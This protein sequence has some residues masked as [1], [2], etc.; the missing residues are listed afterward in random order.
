MNLIGVLRVSTDG[1]AGKDGEGLERQRASVR[2]IAERHGADLQMIEIIDVSGSDVAD[3]LVWNDQ[4]LPALIRDPDAHV[5]ADALDRLVR[6]DSFDLRVLQRLK[7]LRRRIYLPDQTYDLALPT[8]VMIVTMFAA[9]GGHE[10]ASINRRAN[11]GKEAHR[12]AGRW[13]SGS[14]AVGIAYDKKTS[15][16]GYTEDAALVRDAFRAYVE[17]RATADSLALRLGRSR[18][19]MANILR[20]PLYKGLMVIDEKRGE[21]Y[22]KVRDGKQPHRRHVKRAPDEIISVRVYGGEGQLEQLVPDGMWDAAQARLRAN[23]EGQSRS[24]EVTAPQGYFSGFLRPAAAPDVTVDAGQGF[25]RYSLRETRH[26]VYAHTTGA[27]HNNIVRYTCCCKMPRFV[28]SGIGRCDV[29]D[30]PAMRVNAAVD[31][32][33][34]DLTTDPEVLNG[35]RADLDEKRPDGAVERRVLERKIEDVARREARLADLYVDGR[36]DR[37]VHDKRQDALR[38]EKA[39]LVDKLGRLDSTPEG[40]TV[41]QIE[42]LGHA[43]KFDASWSHTAKRAWLKR[44]VWAIHVSRKGVESITLRLPAQGDGVVRYTAQAGRT[45]DDL[46]GRPA[47]VTTAEACA[48]LGTT[49]KRLK[50]E[51]R[52]GRV[53]EPRHRTEGGQRLWTTGEI[54][55]ARAVLA[56][57]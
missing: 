32:Y 17:D 41:A 46:Q 6:A 48:L 11:E 42:A 15:R 36:I 43:W 20:N 9:V 30:P 26:V 40:P 37:V 12:K 7:A 5:A 54:E 45:W 57:A 1:Q 47:T 50:A 55:A 53:A 38:A 22:A 2:R 16:W 21:P 24:R 33:L 25:V 18:G 13:V 23:A 49:Y 3:S 35:M 56:L 10:K 44:Y 29:G 39:D 19:T 28:A 4:V 52:A 8:D 51:V 27:L 14:I 31:R 34:A